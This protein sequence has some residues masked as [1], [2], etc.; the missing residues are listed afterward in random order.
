MFSSQNYSIT[1]INYVSVNDLTFK[2]EGELTCTL[3]ANSVVDKFV[4]F[5]SNLLNKT[6]F[7][8]LSKLSPLETICMKCQTLLS[9]NFG[10]KRR[11]NILNCYLLKCLPITPGYVLIQQMT[12]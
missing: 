3:W 12:N 1:T 4:A 11:K 7:N 5:F 6:R 2:S 10:G 9:E 8:I